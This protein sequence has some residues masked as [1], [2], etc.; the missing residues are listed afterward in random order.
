MERRR[1]ASN[2][3]ITAW[4]SVDKF[5]GPGSTERRGGVNGEDGA[6]AAAACDE[7]E[8]TDAMKV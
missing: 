3:C 8:S 6:A 2:A 5:E 4:E 7:G 1:I